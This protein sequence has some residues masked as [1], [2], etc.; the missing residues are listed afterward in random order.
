MKHSISFLFSFPQTA[1]T[2][3][4]SPEMVG[5]CAGDGYEVSTKQGVHEFV[6]GIP[7]QTQVS[8]GVLEAIRE[9]NEEENEMTVTYEKE[10]CEY[11]YM[12]TLL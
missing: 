10:K 8:N 2:N 11:L 7:S 12:F 3:K 5:L 9:F 4:P 6:L 1:P